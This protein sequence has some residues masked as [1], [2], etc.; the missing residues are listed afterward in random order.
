M[1]DINRLVRALNLPR[2]ICH[3]MVGEQH[4]CKHRLA[5]GMVVIF[6]G[7]GIA[8]VGGHFHH[9]LP[10]ALF[11][12]AVGY[13]VHGIGALPFVELVLAEKAVEAVVAAEEAVEIV[14]LDIEIEGLD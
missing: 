3:H 5:V 1:A 10:L 8:F 14:L 6:A 12:D 2:W 7:V 11:L 13:L 9:N 4:T